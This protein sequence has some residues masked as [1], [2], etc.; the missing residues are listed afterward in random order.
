MQKKKTNN[1]N[2]SVRGETIIG[3]IKTDTHKL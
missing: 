2:F 1:D 3:T